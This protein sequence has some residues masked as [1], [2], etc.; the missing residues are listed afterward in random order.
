MLMLMLMQLMMMMIMKLMMQVVLTILRTSGRARGWTELH[1]SKR[2][3]HALVVLLIITHR[4]LHL[5]RPAR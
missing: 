3:E 2:A 1:P 5:R 4:L